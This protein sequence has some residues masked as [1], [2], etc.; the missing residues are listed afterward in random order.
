MTAES[1]AHE[2]QY[3]LLLE[4][5]RDKETYFNY[6]FHEAGRDVNEFVNDNKVCVTKAA[7]ELIVPSI[8][9]LQALSERTFLFDSICTGCVKTGL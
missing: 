4:F 2:K 3:L 8:R 1:G 9:K 5:G 7:E 6:F